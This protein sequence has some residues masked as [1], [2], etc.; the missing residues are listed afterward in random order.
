MGPGMMGS[1]GHGYTHGGVGCPGWEATSTPQIT[2]E[3]AKVLA[4]QYT[5]QYLPG[6]KVERLLPFTGMH[7]T[8]YS[9]QGSLL[10][11]TQPNLR[12]AAPRRLAGELARRYPAKPSCEARSA[13]RSRAR[14]SG[15]LVRRY[16]AKRASKARSAA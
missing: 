8:M 11:V 7:H 10:A 14:L 6:F 12:G 1:G 5:E 15:E 16:P 9:W 3:K 4:Q 2:E 13:R